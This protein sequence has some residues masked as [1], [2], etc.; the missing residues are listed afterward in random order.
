MIFLVY[1]TKNI[2]MPFIKT[3][4]KDFVIKDDHFELTPEY[5]KDS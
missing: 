2:I 1:N 3:L 4:N 5:L